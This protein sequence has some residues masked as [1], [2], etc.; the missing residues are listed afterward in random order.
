MS[1][2]IEKEKTNLKSDERVYESTNDG[3]TDLCN[4]RKLTKPQINGMI[5][6]YAS[7][8]RWRM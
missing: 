3:A 2:G 7:T 8:K 6:N 1:D 4:F 5:H